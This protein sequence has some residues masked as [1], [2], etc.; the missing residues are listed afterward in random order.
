MQTQRRKLIDHYVSI[1]RGLD[2]TLVDKVMTYTE[3][4]KSPTSHEISMSTFISE[5]AFRFK[6]TNSFMISL[7]FN[8]I[9]NCRGGSRKS[10][11]VEE[12]SRMIC[13][14]LTSD[15]DI[16][17]NFVF[18]VYDLD[19]DGL[20]TKLEVHTLLMTTISQAGDEQDEMLKD[21]I[22]IVMKV[23]DRDGSG[24]ID[25]SEFRDLVKKDVL[26]IEL[27]GQV[28]P[29]DT[30]IQMFKNSFL[31]KTDKQMKDFFA[32]ERAKNVVSCSD[33]QKE[34]TYYP[35]KLECD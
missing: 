20:L 24:T 12:Y 25:L 31:K 34:E 32:R 6:L 30:G 10:V 8:N 14:F 1:F 15:V 23:V 13:I 28:I 7:I 3:C 11:T 9:N 21:L 29:D 17:I 22:E 27:L 33:T 18:D 35:L 5:M 4:L 16:K 19:S 2:Y 26:Y